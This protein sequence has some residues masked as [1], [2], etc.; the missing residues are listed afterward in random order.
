MILWQSDEPDLARGEGVLR[1]HRPVSIARSILGSDLNRI[2]QTS[3][4]RILAA[5]RSA[6]FRWVMSADWGKGL[7]QRDEVCSIRLGW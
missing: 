7:A 2:G 3:S 5:V 4:S 1:Q 6:Y